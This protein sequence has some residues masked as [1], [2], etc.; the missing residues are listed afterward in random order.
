MSP[1]ES[2]LH[3][4][5]TNDELHVLASLERLATDYLKR[6]SPHTHHSPASRIATDAAFHARRDHRGPV[7]FDFDVL[8]M[9]AYPLFAPIRIFPNDRLDDLHTSATQVGC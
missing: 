1:K 8:A 3:L 2:A 4:P 5:G 6:G 9:R 7:R